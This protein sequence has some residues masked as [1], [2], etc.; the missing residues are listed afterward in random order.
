MTKR[1]LVGLG[2]PHGDD[3]IGWRIAESL[4]GVDNVDERVRTAATPADLLDW[5]EGIDRLIVIDAC[6]ND[7]APGAIHRWRWP[8]APAIRHATSS[9]DLGLIEVLNI[10]SRLGQLPALVEVFGI[11]IVQAGPGAPISPALENVLPRLVASFR[12]AWNHA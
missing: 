5:L 9:H 1:L 3:Q 11:E 4:T 12:I 6:Q 10:A 2:S 7:G 8:D